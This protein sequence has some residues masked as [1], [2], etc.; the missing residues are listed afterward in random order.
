M[1]IL[2]AF[3]LAFL[4]LDFYIKYISKYE[5]KYRLLELVLTLIIMSILILS[6]ILSL[7]NNSKHFISKNQVIYQF[8]YIY[9]KRNYLI[10]FKKNDQIEKIY[11]DEIEYEEGLNDNIILIDYFRNDRPF[12]EILLGTRAIKKRVIRLNYKFNQY[13]N[14]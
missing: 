1:I 8:N 4:I 7:S 12:L 3:V 6:M 9:I 11:F 13:S 14:L 10:M 5:F 2:L